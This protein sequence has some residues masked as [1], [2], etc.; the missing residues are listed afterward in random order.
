MGTWYILDDSIRYEWIDLNLKNV[1]KVVGRIINDIDKFVDE[2]VVQEMIQKCT[3]YRLDVRK[4]VTKADE[5]L[6]GTGI[7]KRNLKYGKGISDS[8]KKYNT[9]NKWAPFG[10]Y[11]ICLNKLYDDNIL[12]VQYST[13]HILNNFRNTKVSSHFIDVIDDIIKNKFNERI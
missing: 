9:V 1:I 3:F 10:K 5:I 4:K 7:R 11:R 6:I 8:P 13:G 12:S 2:N